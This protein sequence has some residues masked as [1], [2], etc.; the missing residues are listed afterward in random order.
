MGRRAIAAL[1]ACLGLA[2]CSG[3][4]HSDLRQYV[5]DSDKL[6]H[7]N[8]PP[9]PEVKPYE[10]YTYNAFDLTDPFKPRKIEPP[11][12]GGGA[13]APAKDGSLTMDAIAKTFRYLDDEELAAQRK[14]DKDAKKGPGK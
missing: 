1:F 8:V 14:K 4:E 10:P 5:K 12:G 9:L 13:L 2:A 11:K 7:G 6:P 3:D